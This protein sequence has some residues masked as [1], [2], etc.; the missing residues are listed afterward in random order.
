MNAPTLRRLALILAFPLAGLGTGSASFDGV[1]DSVHFYSHSDWSTEAIDFGR[2]PLSVNM[3][4]WNNE[5]RRGGTPRG[6]SFD[7][8]DPN[9]WDSGWVYLQ[10]R[11]RDKARNLEVEGDFAGSLA[12]Y[13]LLWPGGTLAAFVRDREEVIQQAKGQDSEALQQYLKGRYIAQFGSPDQA[14]TILQAISSPPDYLRP[15]IEYALASLLVGSRD[16]KGRA[17]AKVAKRYAGSPRAES[18][19]I[20]AARSLLTSEEQIPPTQEEIK[21][22]NRHLDQLLN[23]F[24]TTRF[25][26]N[27]IGWRG[28]AAFITGNHAAAAELYVQQIEEARD[29]S[30]AWVGYASLVDI[31]LVGGQTDR[32]VIQLLRQWRQESRPNLH[33]AGAKRLGTIF[34]TLSTDQAR[35]VQAEVRRNPAL[36]EAY[37]GFRIEHTRLTPKTEAT[38]MEFATSAL[39]TMPQPPASL[40]AWIAQTNYNAGRYSSARAL[41]TRALALRPDIESKSRARYVLA[42]SL[43]RLGRHQEA[44]RQGNMLLTPATPGYLRQGIAEFLA[45][46]QE[47]H[48][49]PRRALELY[50]GMDYEGDIA[51][52]ADAK[53]TTSQLKTIIDR[54]FRYPV[55]S[56]RSTPLMA[57]PGNPD[58]NKSL[59]KTLQYTLAMRYLRAEKYDLARAAFLRI[60]REERSNWGMT[61]VARKYKF[62]DETHIGFDRAPSLR[63]PIDTVAK[64]QSMTRAIRQARTSDQRAQAIYE[65]AAFIYHESTLVFYSPSLW[66]GIRAMWLEYLWNDHLANDHDRRALDRHRHEHESLAQSMRLCEMIIKEH[67]K[68]AVMPKALYTAAISAARLSNFSAGWREQEGELLRHAINR[69]DRIAREYKNDPLYKNAVKYKSEYA[70]MADT[71]K[72]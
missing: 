47:R 64:L 53:L 2:A 17:F 63:D 29:P 42:G 44:I 31:A 54:G 38:L 8:A 18:A 46:E 72:Y 61:P 33:L 9:P 70:S 67:P 14:R 55:G 48:G 68:S 43:S 11:Y 10:N 62:G 51:Y 1:A 7:Y 27:A 60:P 39:Q 49:D 6:S 40:V 71:P 19:L 66:Q 26:N 41:A 58:R 32:A 34:Q 23:Q 3:I 59:R 28:R 13:K 24:P 69:M 12:R 56:L 45:L 65:K 16:E 36:L 21:S 20:M 52:L 50:I 15:H 30:E 4:T 5:P 22:A 57:E 25:R 37:V 35:A